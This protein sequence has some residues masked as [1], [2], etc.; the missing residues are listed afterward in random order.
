MGILV[1]KVPLGQMTATHS[2]IRGWCNRS[3]SGRRIKWNQPP[4]PKSFLTVLPGKCRNSVQTALALIHKNLDGT[5]RG[6]MK[7]VSWYFPEGNEENHEEAVRIGGVPTQIRTVNLHYTVACI[8]VGTQWPLDGRIYQGL[9]RQ[10][11]VKYIPVAT[12]KYATIEVLF[13]MVFSARSVK[14]AYKENNQQ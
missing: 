5:G 7:T 2:I 11:L 6:L 1:D 8:T 14:R 10:R 9:S 4:S 13:Q 3:I 12:D